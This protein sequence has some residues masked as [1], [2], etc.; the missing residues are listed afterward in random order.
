[1]KK[2]LKKVLDE[3][4]EID[5]DLKNREKELLEI[6]EKM[7]ELKPN[8]KID[9]N[10]KNELRQKIN[11]EI[12]LKKLSLRNEKKYNF[13][14][15]FSYV[16]WTIGVLSL[17]SVVYLMWLDNK[18]ILPTNNLQEWK[19]IS[20]SNFIKDFPEWFGN[21]SM[22]SDIDGG[23]KLSWLVGSRSDSS[24]KNAENVPTMTDF[25]KNEQVEVG[26]LYW[27]G[28]DDWWI[29]AYRYNFT[30][31]LNIDLD[32]NLAVYKKTFS[33]MDTSSLSNLI[34]KLNFN[35]MTL[36]KFYPFEINNINLSQKWAN[37]Y[38]ININL[39]ENSINF[40]KKSESLHEF[41]DQDKQ[42]EIS[43]KDLVEIAQNFMKQNNID[44]SNYWKAVIDDNFYKVMDDYKKQNRQTYYPT[45]SF[46]VIYPLLVE[47]KEVI[48]DSF[49][50][51][52]VSLE[53]DIKE[54]NVISMNGLWENS[55]LKSFYKAEINKNNILKIA[56][57]WWKQSFYINWVNDENKINYIDVNLVNPRL[58]Y[59]SYCTYEKSKNEMYLIPSIIFETKKDEWKGDFPEHILVPLLKDFYTY[60]LDWNIVWISEK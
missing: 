52:W 41:E 25:A 30:W 42:F 46:T 23:N 13:K 14:L 20:F 17:I 40:Y 37:S 1:M 6:V 5:S 18:N 55:F 51:V 16:F 24:I 3:L 39:L 19:M 53:V 15:L 50:N 12:K 29:D 54:K 27:Q 33:T 28:E 38:N 58:V 49:R 9:E 48:D 21:I 47:W 56:S 7:L 45:N 36:E 57:N 22:L 2:S 31:D 26:K 59:V 43:E 10:F 44:L 4:Y 11:D 32:E 35:W 60:D 8:L 34:K